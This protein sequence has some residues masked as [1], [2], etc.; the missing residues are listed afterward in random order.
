MWWSGKEIYFFNVPGR[1]Q[2]ILVGISR[3][4]S[5]LQVQFV[6]AREVIVEATGAEKRTQKRR[7][8]IK[9]KGRKITGARE[10][11]CQMLQRRKLGIEKCH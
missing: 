7:Y 1:S 9:T 8:M 4:I 10:G 5:E 3:E 11:L 6:I 2:V